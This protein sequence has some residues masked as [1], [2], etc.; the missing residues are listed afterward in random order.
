M[1][2]ENKVNCEL[3]AIAAIKIGRCQRQSC[4]RKIEV[5]A[6]RIDRFGLL[7]PVIVDQDNQLISGF[8]RVEAVKTLE[9]QSVPAIRLDIPAIR[10]GMSS[11][12]KNGGW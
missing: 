5:L 4:S 1:A 3:I 2:R 9:W 10:N 8:S 11:S 7:E 12:S 6:E